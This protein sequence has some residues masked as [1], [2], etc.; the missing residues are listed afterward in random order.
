MVVFMM[1]VV[2]AVLAVNLYNYLKIPFMFFPSIAAIGFF[3]LGH[4]LAVRKFFLNENLWWVLPLLLGAWAMC[5]ST[6]K[7]LV[8]GRC[9]YNGF[10][11]CDLL[12]SLGIFISLYFVVKKC[13]SN[14]VIW[15]FFKWCGVNSL[16]ILCVHSVE[17]NFVNFN[18]V[19][20][21][22]L[23]VFF[24]YELYIAI[25]FRLAFDMVVTYALIKSRFVKR[26][27]FAQYG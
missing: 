23:P 15:K 22:L 20:R 4:M 5:L 3:A 17:L 11:I 24:P 2:M 7:L 27:I 19:K 8:V 18:A 6:G 25:A 16:I 14:A 13:S 12:G 1:V 26:Y 9:E 21:W 10:Y